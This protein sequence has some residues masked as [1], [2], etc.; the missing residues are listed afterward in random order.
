MQAFD[1]RRGVIRT[2]GLPGAARA[3][4]PRA[5]VPMPDADPYRVESLTGREDEGTSA[6]ATFLTFC[7]CLISI[8]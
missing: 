1:P 5:P 4:P 3:I 6:S 2:A 7:N 8:E